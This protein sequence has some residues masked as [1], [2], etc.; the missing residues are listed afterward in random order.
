MKVSLK[1]IIRKLRKYEV[2]IRKAVHS[3]MHGNYKSIFKGSGIEFSDL[4]EYQYGDDIRTIDWNVTAKGHGSYVRL[5]Q[6][7]K[8]QHIIFLV[9]VSASLNIGKDN[10][11]KF[12]IIKEI[13]GVLMLSAVKEG[14]EIGLVCYSDKKELYIAPDKGIKHAY[15]L[16]SKLFNLESES[17]LTDLN[18]ATQYT[19]SILKRKSIVIVLSDFIDENYDKN[20]ISLSKKHDLVLIQI[21][22]TREI[23]LPSMGIIPL[24]DTETN[25]TIWVNSSS[26]TF[27]VNME[28][29]QRAI[30]TKLENFSKSYESNYT[31]IKTHE[32]YIIKLVELFRVRNFHKK[33]A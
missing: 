5:F 2:R 4:R 14:S 17:A 15:Y 10:Q 30:Q 6:E 1:D 21:Q 12:D 13:A 28:K 23:H 9:D 32:D 26:K 19:L 11:T 7:D 31:C 16:I 18:K 24:V 8:E 20:L 27:R 25:K 29:R 22:D 33:S 3:H